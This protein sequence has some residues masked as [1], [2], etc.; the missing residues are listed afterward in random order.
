MPSSASWAVEAASLISL[1]LS[2]IS[3]YLAQVEF[4]TAM[5]S[6]ARILY[7]LPA[8]G[9]YNIFFVPCGR[10]PVGLGLVGVVFDGAAEL[11]GRRRKLL[12]AGGVMVHSLPSFLTCPCLLMLNHVLRTTRILLV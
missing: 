7:S 8:Q 9:T 4:T 6:P 1:H 12:A 2:D 5:R 10:R 11:L 3:L